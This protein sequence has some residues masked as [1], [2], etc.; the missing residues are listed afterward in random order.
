[1]A[2]RGVHELR[3]HGSEED[4]RLRVAHADD[5]A[6]PQQQPAHHVPAVDPPAQRGLVDDPQSWGGRSPRRTSCRS[7]RTW[8]RRSTSSRPA[9]GNPPRITARA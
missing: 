5:K 7:I 4:D 2:R 3:Q 6:V 1:M 8:T 9:D